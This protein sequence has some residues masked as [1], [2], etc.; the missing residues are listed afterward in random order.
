MFLNLTAGSA[1]SAAAVAA[2]TTSS[3]SS[4]RRGAPTREYDIKTGTAVT[5]RKSKFQAHYAVVHSELEAREAVEQLKS[6]NK[7]IATATHN[8]S[9]YRIV[10]PSGEIVRR[11]WRSTR[12]IRSRC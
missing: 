3:S 7:K 9:A 2:T 5:D 10:L 12:S 6:S 4:T 1:S 11:R 8:I